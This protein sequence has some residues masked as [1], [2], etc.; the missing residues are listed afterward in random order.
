MSEQSRHGKREAPPERTSLREYWEQHKEWVAGLSRGQRVRYRLFQ[1][2]VAVC[3]LIIVLFLALQA[4]IRLPDV[5]DLPGT[6]PDSSQGG[7]DLFEGA[8]LPEVAKSGRK[9]GYYTFL[10]VGQDVVSGGTDTILLFTFDT[11]RKSLHAMSIL[12]D[13]MINTSATSK[14]INSVYARNRGSSDL[15]AK[16]RAEK[17]MAALRQE[18]SRLTGVYPD[19]YVL[20]EWDAIGELVEALGG[21]WF[22]VPFDMDY[23]D[24]YQD[25]H[26]HQEAGYRKLS[27]EDAMEVVRWRKN[28]T[29]PSGGDV[30]RT[31]VQQAF[32]G[33]VLDTCLQPAT[34]LKL[35]SLAQVFLD[36]VTTDL[37][38][39][40]L[41][42]FA[43]L[44][45]GMDTEEDVDFVT[46]PYTGVYY[47]GASMVV[48]VEDELLELLNAGLNPYQD[49][50]RSRD[51]QLVFRNADGSFGVT[52]GTLLDANMAR[53]TVTPSDPDEEDDEEGE[54]DGEEP[55]DQE[56]AP[57]GDGDEEQPP[58]EGEDEPS[59]G[60]DTE[61]E[62][63]FDP[64]E[65]L[66]D[67]DEVLPDPGQPAPSPE[68]PAEE[69]PVA[70]LPARPEPAER[71]A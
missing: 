5:P 8:E 46:M 41:L 23:D 54:P 63:P 59:G 42:A 29:G 34:L 32:L 14:R 45:V 60:G 16:E 68:E 18:V 3:A 33:A 22:D 44:A 27:G 6:D 35:P 12:R 57:G 62:E 50:I 65:L 69:N 10:V 37:S 24:P 21:V 17:G 4:W 26:I 67:P 1:A 11:E 52:N 25:L 51:L 38:I 19:F 39:G 13:T 55:E 58:Q 15:P 48:A 64:D 7:G 71:A 43:Q 9:P 49:E 53:P 2:L 61:G 66:P 40:N 70:V 47:R 28:N 30:V 20:V 31:Q 36:N 56:P